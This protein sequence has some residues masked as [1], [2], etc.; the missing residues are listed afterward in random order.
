MTISFFKFLKGKWVFIYLDTKETLKFFIQ[1]ELKHPQLIKHPLS[2]NLKD[3]FH[4]FVN[5]I[6]WG[7]FEFSIIDIC[8]LSIQKV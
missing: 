6:G 5:S 8:D 3:R 2:Y 4:R 1:V 7:K